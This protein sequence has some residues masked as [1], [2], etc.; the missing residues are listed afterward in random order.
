MAPALRMTRSIKEKLPG[1]FFFHC[2]LSFDGR[3][4]EEKMK[5]KKILGLSILECETMYVCIYI[6]ST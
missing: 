6:F 5:K 3:E 4:E 2:G 1:F